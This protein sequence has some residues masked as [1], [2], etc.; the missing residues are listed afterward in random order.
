MR[1]DHR[2][3]RQRDWLLRLHGA[4]EAAYGQLRLAGELE[5]QAVALLKEAEASRRR[6]KELAPPPADAP[7]T[8]G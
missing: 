1:Q 7:R 6:T 5:R 4:M 2:A 8:A 3:R